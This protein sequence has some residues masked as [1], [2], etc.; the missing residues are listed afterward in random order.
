MPNNFFDDII[1]RKDPNE[2]PYAVLNQYKFFVQPFQLTTD[3]PNRT[4]NF[5]ANQMSAPTPMTVGQ[6]GPVEIH[7][8]Q[9]RRAFDC[10]VRIED[11]GSRRAL[12]NRDCHIRT[13]AGSGQRPYILPKNFFLEQRRT[14]LWTFT[15]ISGNANLV[16]PVL[17]G[18]R[19]YKQSAPGSILDDMIASKIA[20]QMVTTPYWLTTDT[21]VVLTP[22]EQ[23]TVLCTV[24]GEG[25]LSIKKLMVISDEPLD[26]TIRD[27]R[28]QRSL[29][30]GNINAVTGAGNAEYP[31]IFPI[32]FLVERNS[33]IEVV[34][35]NLSAVNNNTVYWTF[36]GT[37][38][39]VSEGVS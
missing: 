35:T 28:S 2:K 24:G 6:E 3:A 16:E 17:E 38:I 4:I 33:V 18:V 15:D 21:N 29:S 11:V 30:S 23:R 19:F 39:Y 12:M 9:C 14:L 1:W 10:L 22:S 13:V 20:Q 32:T 31:H 7:F 27:A 5:L 36:G 8:V 25:H 26:Y 37:R 34:L